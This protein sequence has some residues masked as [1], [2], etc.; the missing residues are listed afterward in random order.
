MSTRMAQRAIGDIMA[1]CLGARPLSAMRWLGSFTAHLPECWRSRSLIPADRSCLRV[2]ARFQTST[3]AIVSLPGEY[4]AGAREMYSRDVY[5]RN[6]VR[7]PETGWVVDLGANRGLFC[8]WAALTGAQVV[9]VEAQQGFAAGIR[10][11]AECNRVADRV[12]VEIALASGVVL[13]GARVG[14]V[15]DDHRWATTSH[16]AATRPSD[17]SVAQLMLEHEIDRI[18]LL[19]IDIEGGEFAV[20]RVDEDLRW[21]DR[22]DQLALEVHRDFSDAASLI[23]RL[24][25]CGFTV[26]LRDNDGRRVTADSDR[27]D[28]AYCQ[29]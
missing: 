6:G 23:D 29:R 13:S 21:L 4:T 17:V 5:L 28:Y 3:G 16:G 2:G 19:K 26:D 22:V 11:L 25:A 20:F 7:I 24:R 15:A 14:I 8:V 12:Q 27:L 18:D 9:A 1:V 10:H